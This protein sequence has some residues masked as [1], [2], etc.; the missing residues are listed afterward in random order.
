MLNW[1]AYFKPF[2]LLTF[3]IT[4][5]IEIGVFF[6]LENL[7]RFLKLLPVPEIKIAVFNLLRPVNCSTKFNFI[8]P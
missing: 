1:A 4:K 7:I 2:A 3:E 5:L 6:I 8:F